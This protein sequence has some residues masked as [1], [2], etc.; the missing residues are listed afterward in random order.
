MPLCL[1]GTGMGVGWLVCVREPQ[2]ALEEELLCT[3]EVPKGLSQ[4]NPVPAVRPSRGKDKGTGYYMP[5][6]SKSLARFRELTISVKTSPMRASA[7]SR[8]MTL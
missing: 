7:L 3:R 8:P 1:A 4:T 2:P 5:A 6:C